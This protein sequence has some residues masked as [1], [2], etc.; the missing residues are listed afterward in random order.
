M[1]FNNFLLLKKIIIT[2]NLFIF[3]KFLFRC[4]LFTI[5]VLIVL[6]KKNYYHVDDYVDV[7][8]NNLFVCI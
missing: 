2:V 3:D 5:Y 4:C 7:N 8:V 6:N 1:L